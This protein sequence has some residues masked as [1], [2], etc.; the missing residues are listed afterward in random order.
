[1]THGLSRTVLRPRI[2]PPPLEINT[3][4]LSL[5]CT[6][7]ITQ[8]ALFFNPKGPVHQALEAPEELAQDLHLLQPGIQEDLGEEAQE[9]LLQ[10]PTLAEGLPQPF[11]ID[12]E[13]RLHLLQY[14]KEDFLHH[15]FLRK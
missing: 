13:A 9:D 14:P 11:L 1:L 5:A 8:C 7:W 4:N 10:C 6:E 3:P 12:L 15:S 2:F